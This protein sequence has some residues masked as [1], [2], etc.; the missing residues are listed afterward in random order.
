MKERRRVLILGAA[1]FAMLAG[2]VGMRGDAGDQTLALDVILAG[3]A[4]LAVIL[5]YG[6]GR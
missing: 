2:L 3:G 1:F 5:W 6:R 4:G